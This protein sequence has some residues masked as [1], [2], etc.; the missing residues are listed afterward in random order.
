MIYAR[1][2]IVQS[3]DEEGSFNIFGGGFQ[4]DSQ[5]SKFIHQIFDPSKFAPIKI[6][7]L[8][9]IRLEHESL[10]HYNF[11]CTYI[12]WKLHQNTKIETFKYLFAIINGHKNKPVYSIQ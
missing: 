10:F 4:L 6:F 2:C 9:G 11:L 8:Y 3:F 1:Y 5:K 7:A 12:L